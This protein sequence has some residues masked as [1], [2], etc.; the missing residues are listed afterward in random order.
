MSSRSPWRPPGWAGRASRWTSRR[1]AT[2]SP[3]V[4][5]VSSTSS[6]PP[7]AQASARSPP[8]SPRRS[9]T[10]RRCGLR[11]PPRPERVPAN[12][13]QQPCLDIR[14]AGY[15]NP[16]A[17]LAGGADNLLH[18]LHPAEELSAEVRVQPVVLAGSPGQIPGVHEHVSRVELVDRGLHRQDAGVRIGEF[19]VRS[20]RIVQHRLH[21]V[22]VN[23]PRG[24]GVLF[25]R[26]PAGQ[27]DAGTGG[28]KPGK[29]FGQV[30]HDVAGGPA[31]DRG[32]R[33]PGPGTVDPVREQPGNLPV[34][35]G[36][37]V[38]QCHQTAPSLS[39][40]SSLA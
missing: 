4:P 32:R 23:L 40:L 24:D 15:L 8:S 29:P 25:Y 16:G 22:A 6:W 13:A 19:P 21:T 34:P 26:R 30:T 14:T 5:R 3:R 35:L 10:P 11:S 17:V 2:A 9:A 28:K 12:E 38:R 37:A 36:W 1:A 39:I 7:R 33:V 27:L 18:L 31:S 20:L